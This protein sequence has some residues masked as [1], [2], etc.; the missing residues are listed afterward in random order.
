MSRR[1]VL[2]LGLLGASWLGTGCGDDVKNGAVRLTIRYS[3][4]VPGCVRVRA[5]DA[6]AASNS[7]EQTLTAA[8]TTFDGQLVVAVYREKSWSHDLKLTV[9]A[10]EQ[11]C[12]GA[13]VATQTATAAV[14]PGKITE[15]TTQ[16]TAT[17][18][19]GD[20]WIAP[21]NGGTD[22]ADDASTRFPGATEVCNAIDEDCDGE[23]DDGAPPI[24]TWA[25]VDG[26]GFGAGTP[27]LECAPSAGRA[28]Q[29]ND[30]NDGNDQ[31]FPGAPE[32]CNGVDDDC[33]TA[34]DDGLTFFAT[35]ADGDADGFGTGTAVQE[36]AVSPG[37]AAQ[38]GDCA[39]GNGQIFPGAPERCD[40]VDNNCDTQNNEGFTVGAA[41]PTGKTCPGQVA[42]ETDGGTRCAEQLL[43]WFVDFD[44][45]QLGALDA[46]T[47]LACDPPSGY[48]A[49]S[50]DCDDGDP[51]TY[52]AAAEL[53]DRKD[54]DCDGTS[55][56]GNVCGAGDGGWALTQ[57]GGTNNDWKTVAAV[58]AG[59]WWMGGRDSNLAPGGAD[60]VD[61][62]D[63]GWADRYATCQSA[64]EWS[65]SWAYQNAS[66]DSTVFLAGCV[67]SD[68]GTDCARGALAMA[69]TK[70]ATCLVRR[71]VTS[72]TQMRSVV[73]I[74]EA[75]GLRVFAVGTG[76]LAYEAHPTT[77]QPLGPVTVNADLYDIHGVS[78][79]SVYAAG[80][81]TNGADPR[82]FRYDESTGS[83]QWVSESGVEMLANTTENGKLLGIWVV[84][85]DLVFAVG[86][87]GMVLRKAGGTW[88][89]ITDVTG[90][91]TVR[92]VRAFGH[93]SVYVAAGNEA[94][95]W[96]GA[97]WE[98]IYDGNDITRDLAGVRPDQ[99]LIVADDGDVAYS[100]R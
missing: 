32:S 63:G 1:I 53:C 28:S 36:C 62:R 9:T 95:R 82:V 40:G 4:F 75:A 17:D 93:N 77:L 85:E 80:S 76:G 19:D 5:E 61:N 49:A 48:V 45:D 70:S 78:S 2:A 31:V 21:A 10:H 41:C 43:T 50:A 64:S 71:E 59:W 47:S 46:G 44:R 39:D 18:A 94:Y 8:N 38:A 6:K 30:C 42:C 87:N 84:H 98:H 74:R 72:A 15:T 97:S 90:T 56:E 23:I 16:L 66:D 73:G 57:L 55:D 65:G 35:Y 24:E 37:R 58:D 60:L 26:D 81:T 99:L 54:N 67:A 69:S 14:T 91:P 100:R 88:S 33:D 29:A 52:A 11:S 12:T 68:A 83:P 7:D 22:C 92:S 51:F 3:G 86:E 79:T 27:I 20:G 34:S 13:Q 25:D 96:N 89:V